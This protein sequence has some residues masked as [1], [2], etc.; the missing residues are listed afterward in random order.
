MKTKHILSLATDMANYTVGDHGP[1]A[2]DTFQDL[3]VKL[4][5]TE[6]LIFMRQYITLIE[7]QILEFITVTI[8]QK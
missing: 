6:K 3:L 8:N 1:F 4:N 5:N 2:R 7:T